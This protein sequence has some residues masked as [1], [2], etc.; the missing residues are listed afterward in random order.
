M[1]TLILAL[2]IGTAATMAVAQSKQVP[3]TSASTAGKKMTWYDMGRPREVIV[4]PNLVVD[5]NGASASTN[6][7]PVARYNGLSVWEQGGQ[8]ARA[9]KQK[10][11]ASP[12]LRESAGGPM[13]A[14][15]GAVIVQLD[16]RWTPAQ[17]SVWL[18]A[19][20]L[21]MRNALPIGKNIIVIEGAPGLAAL[22]LANTLHAR[23]EVTWA[24]PDW[25]VEMQHH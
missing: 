11:S 16:E 20:R 2:L 12:V 25:W 8:G 23:P 22:E 1:H 14:L 5:F 4:D 15:P 10:G 9:A 3:N 21:T 18:A 24:Q 7:R 6:E 13:R 19:N 17:I